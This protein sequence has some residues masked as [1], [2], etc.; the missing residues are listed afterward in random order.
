MGQLNRYRYATIDNFTTTS[1][2]ERIPFS[3]ET[4]EWTFDNSFYQTPGVIPYSSFITIN[5]TDYSLPAPV[6]DIRGDCLNR[7]TTYREC[8][9]GELLKDD[10]NSPD[11]E[12]CISEEGFSWG[13]S[14]FLIFIRV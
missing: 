3:I 12:F 10:W 13:F 11:N 1:E 9:K 6:L 2:S 14:S 7:Y 8:Y 5:N 4:G